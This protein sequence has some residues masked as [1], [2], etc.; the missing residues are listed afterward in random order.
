[1]ALSART[2]RSPFVEQEYDQLDRKIDSVLGRLGGIFK[3]LVWL[4]ALG[5]LTYY[6][7]IP[8]LEA[9]AP[10]M[11][12]GAYLIFQLFFAIMFMIVQFAALFWFL[13][14]TRV[15]WIMPG[16]TG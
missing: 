8:N 9:W 13:G 14:R 5:L 6:V 11:M 1:M 15:Y 3:L 4:T 2:A 10:Y 7:L 16:E 12:F